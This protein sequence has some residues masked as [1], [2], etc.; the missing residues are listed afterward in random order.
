MRSGAPGYPRILVKRDDLTG[1]ALGGKSR[2]LEFLL[3]DALRQHSGSH[4]RSHPVQSRAQ[5]R[6]RRPKRRAGGGA[7][8]QR[9]CR[10]VVPGPATSCWMPSSG[11]GPAITRQP[12]AH[13]GDALWDRE[14][15]LAIVPWSLD[16]VG[17]DRVG[18]H[19][20]AGGQGL[21]HVG[22][23]AAPQPDGGP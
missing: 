16:Q 23:V 2:K 21:E 14:H 13:G 4:H 6:G 17:E 10:A 11:R 22:G 1:L 20:A 3:G 8:A 18:D 12:V 15:G 9:H 5:D 19:R 7:R